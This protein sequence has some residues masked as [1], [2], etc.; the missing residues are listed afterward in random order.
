MFGREKK[1]RIAPATAGAGARRHGRRPI[2]SSITGA[3]LPNPDSRVARFELAARSALELL[4]QD[5][6]DE[7]R[8]VRIGFATAPTG[9]GVSEQPLFYSIDRAART[10]VLYRMPIQRARGL[11]VDDEDHRRFFIGHCVHRAVCEYLGREP[12]EVAPGRFEHF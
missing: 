9:E 1:A 11:H 4:R 7:L 3:Q 8:G 10:I 5:V 12:W 6:G 2:R